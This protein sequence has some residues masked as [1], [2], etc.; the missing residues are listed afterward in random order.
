ML[1]PNHDAA[2]LTTLG[3]GKAQ[4]PDELRVLARSACHL[5]LLLPSLP[6]FAPSHRSPPSHLYRTFNEPHV[7]ASVEV[8]TTA[9]C[10]VLQPTDYSS[11]TQVR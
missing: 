3:A 7:L 6:P 1:N 8:Q 2:V 10:E 4:Y 9:T 11:E 5:R